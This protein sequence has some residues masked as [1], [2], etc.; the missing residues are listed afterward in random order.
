MTQIDMVRIG[1]ETLVYR[2]RT[3]VL[4]YVYKSPAKSKGSRDEPKC[5]NLQNILIA[6]A[7]AINHNLSC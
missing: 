7:V 2:D 3:L 4:G 5:A 1:S 6:M